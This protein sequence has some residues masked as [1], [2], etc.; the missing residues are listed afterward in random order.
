MATADE[1]GRQLSRLQRRPLA[2]AKGKD[3]AELSA[4]RSIGPAEDISLSSV[5]NPA[6]T[7]STSFNPPTEPRAM[8]IQSAYAAQGRHP[9][10]A[11]TNH[12]TSYS[13]AMSNQSS[14]ATQHG[15][16]SRFQSNYNPGFPA[17]SL[18]RDPARDHNNPHEP[19][20]HRF[21]SR[22]Q[23]GRGS[24]NIPLAQTTPQRAP[25]P[26]Y[27]H[28]QRETVLPTPPRP[29]RRNPPPNVKFSLDPEAFIAQNLVKPTSQA[30]HNEKVTRPVSGVF[31]FDDVQI[32]D[33]AEGS[34]RSTST[35]QVSTQR[36]VDAQESGEPRPCSNYGRKVP[37][38][39]TSRCPTT[40]E[41]PIVT[42]ANSVLHSSVPV[43]GRANSVR[44]LRIDAD[45]AN[46]LYNSEHSF[47][48]TMVPVTPDVVS[49]KPVEPKQGLSASKY[50]DAVPTPAVR[51]E[52]APLREVT[53][54]ANHPVAAQRLAASEETR[55]RH[56]IALSSA[57]AFWS[58]L[59]KYRQNQT[60]T[61]VAQ[62]NTGYAS[63]QSRYETSGSR[64][65]AE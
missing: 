52:V 6:I 32:D 24:N 63:G 54:Y 9:S 5:A 48:E 30:V 49:Q 7:H 41:V 64:Y 55:A 56:E 10:H 37:I 16:S 46:S 35:A 8:R 25:Q 60:T 14:H 39:V 40:S 53:G 44:P 20:S 59:E 23:R 28:A 22:G 58:T 38:T 61:H 17:V 36:P 34:D 27:Q 62:T 45:L 47:V 4:W 21:F 31:S 13:D 2:T 65:M 43:S 26:T 1:P 11:Q 15:Q 57:D 12:N 3:A 19:P 42:A 18:N 51:A 29:R 50:A 33:Q